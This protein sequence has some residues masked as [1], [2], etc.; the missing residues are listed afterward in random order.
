MSK[1]PTTKITTSPLT[2]QAFAPFGEVIEEKAVA[3][4]IINQ[5]MCGR[6]HDLATLSF[7]PS[8]RAG[9]SLFSAI[10]RTLPYRFQLLERHPLGSQAFLPMSEH[11][12]LVITAPDKGGIPDTPQAFLTRPGQGINFHPNTWHGVLTPLHAPGLF[13]VIDFI[14]ENTTHSN[15]EEYHLPEPIMVTE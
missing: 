13:A 14:P 1:T 3:D 5:G 7:A 2:A 8:G 12:F 6:H 11:P 15:L 9:L 10:P 4:K